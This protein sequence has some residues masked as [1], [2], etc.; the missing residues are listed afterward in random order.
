M[1]KNKH[2]GIQTRTNRTTKNRKTPP[3][4]QGHLPCGR[5]LQASHRPA[6]ARPPPHTGP[7]V[8]H[9]STRH[10]NGKGSGATR[11]GPR[12]WVQHNTSPSSPGRLGVR[13]RP[14]AAAPLQ[15]LHI[16]GHADAHASQLVGEVPEH[17]RHEHLG[18]G[19][20]A[21]ARAA[22]LAPLGLVPAAAPRAACGTH[23]QGSTRTQH[24]HRGM[25]TE[26]DPGGWQGGGDR[27]RGRGA[28]TQ[29][30][31]LGR[32]QRVDVGG[33]AN[34]DVIGQLRGGGELMR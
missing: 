21:V 16:Q 18:H 19:G 20:N 14:D 17:V 10:R 22:V 33:G 15:A 34:G 24:A 29:V 27:C 3:P 9:R 11:V 25:C 8:H 7:I 30:P 1:P 23:K 2:R 28:G 6:G 13:A 31:K 5:R 26:P 4:P 32:R 12:P